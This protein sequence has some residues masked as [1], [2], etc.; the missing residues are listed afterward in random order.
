M[1]H[2]PLT[3]LPDHRAQAAPS[4]PEIDAAARQ[5]GLAVCGALHPARQP[6]KALAGGTL[7]LLGTA[8]AFWPVFKTS[9]EHK[10]GAPHPVDR[11]SERVVGALAEDLGGKAHFPFGG[12]P[13][14]PFVNWALAS[15][16]F[17]TSPSQMMVHDLAGMLI[18]LR[19]ALH[20]EQE[21]D[22]PPPP[23]AESPC[24]S[25]PFRPCLS[26]CPAGALADGGPYNLAACHDY[27]DTPDGGGC[28]TGGCLARRACPLSRNAGRDPQQTA[29]HMR[30]FHPR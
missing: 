30:H 22:I 16:R 26:A 5:A 13:Y 6:V 25:C 17:F 12:P 18:S 20:F 23:L 9:P 27:L 8:G 14:T 1:P 24:R 28:M 21:I 19:G 10:D 15:G 11:W 7:V 3:D 2:V 4:Y 29:H